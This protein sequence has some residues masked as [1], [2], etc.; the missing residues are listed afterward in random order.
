IVGLTPTMG[1]LDRHGRAV[2]RPARGE[3]QRAVK[4]SRTAI[5]VLI[6]WLLTLESAVWT[7]PPSQEAA[8]PLNSKAAVLMDYQTG[9]V[10]YAHN[11]HEPLPPASVT[12]VMT[13]QIGRASCRDR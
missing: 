6:P 1:G 8:M 12:K 3:E 13:L 9:R 11:E 2:R 5:R 4:R 10:L 7:A